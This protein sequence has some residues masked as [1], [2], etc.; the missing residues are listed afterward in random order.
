[1][2]DLLIILTLLLLRLVIPFGLTL[3]VGA[4]VERHLALR[5]E[6]LG[7]TR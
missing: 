1:M 7:W 5:R 4:L 3:L 6:K 2:D